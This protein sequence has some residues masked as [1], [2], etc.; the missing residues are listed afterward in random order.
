MVCVTSAVPQ[1]TGTY[2]TTVLG[3][4]LHWV[5]HTSG[6]CVCTATPASVCMASPTTSAGGA[7]T[8]SHTGPPRHC[9]R[10]QAQY[11][12]ATPI[13]GTAHPHPHPPTRWAVGQAAQ[14]TVCMV[15]PTSTAHGEYQH[16]TRY[17]SGML[18][19]LVLGVYSD[20]DMAPGMVSSRSG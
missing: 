2:S 6:L 20:T 15:A 8:V 13:V 1:C 10:Q 9:L 18:V 4:V 17:S 5:Q 19:L 14:H 12:R 16:S 11:I 3:T 7:A